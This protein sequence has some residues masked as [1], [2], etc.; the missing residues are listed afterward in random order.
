MNRL[1]SNGDKK[2]TKETC[3]MALEGTPEAHLQG[4]SLAA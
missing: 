3:E 4:R 2:G 1:D